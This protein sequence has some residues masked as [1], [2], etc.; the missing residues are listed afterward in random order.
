MV[1]G[2]AMGVQGV[3]LKDTKTGATSELA[4]DGVFVFVGITPNTDFIEVEKDGRGFIKTDRML[5]TSMPGVFAAGD[6]RDSALRQVA[7]AVG[8]GALA[9]FAVEA[10]IESLAKG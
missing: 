4:V 5:Q 7:T 2:D 8:D 9:A 6:C 10:Y 1:N 3:R